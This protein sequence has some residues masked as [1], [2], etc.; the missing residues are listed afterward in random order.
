MSI[1]LKFGGTSLQN[2]QRMVAAAQRIQQNAQ[3][4]PVIVVASAMGGVTRLLRELAG[5]LPSAHDTETV[6]SILRQQHWNVLGDL[7]GL[8]SETH[9]ELRELFNQLE[10][11]VREPQRT[12]RPNAWTDRLLGFGERASVRLLTFTLNKLGQP[13][14]YYES[15]TFIKTDLYHGAARILEDES[16]ALVHEYLGQSHDHIPVVTGFI[17]ETL[18]HRPTTL[19]CSGSDYTASWIAAQL[20]SDALE[21]W[22]D[23][24]GIHTADP[25]RITGAR[26]IHSLNFEQ[27]HRLTQAGSSVIHPAV[28]EP[29]RSHQPELRIRN[30]FNPEHPG[31]TVGEQLD[32]HSDSQLGIYSVIRQQV[33]MIRWQSPHRSAPRLLLDRLPILHQQTSSRTSDEHY[34]HCLVLKTDQAWGLSDELQRLSNLEIESATAIRVITF[35]DPL[36]SDLLTKIRHLFT[37]HQ[38]ISVPHS[39][40]PIYIIGD[41][42]ADRLEQQLHDLLHL[43][44]IPIPI[45]LLGLGNVGQEF[46]DQLA[47]HC[48]ASSFRLI[49]VCDSQHLWLDQ[50]GIDLT[51]LSKATLANQSSYDNPEQLKQLLL[52]I[53][54]PDSCLIDCS[55][56]QEIAQWYPEFLKQGYHIITPSKHAGASETARYQQLQDEIAHQCAFFG[57]ETT[58]GAGLPLLLT[59][60]RLRRAGD[61]I[62]KL[63]IIASGSLN[64]I[65]SQLENGTL[66]SEAVNEAQQR[67]LTEPDPREDL[68]GQD[69]AR[70]ARILA[71]RVGW[72]IPDSSI[73]VHPL[74]TWSLPTLRDQKSRPNNSVSKDTESSNNLSRAD[75]RDRALS[76]KQKLQAQN[77]E[78][79]DRIQQTE[80]HDKVLRYVGTIDEH[81]IEVGLQALDQDHELAQTQGTQN[82]FIIHTDYYDEQPLIIKGPGAGVEVTASGVLGDLLRLREK[83]V[84]ARP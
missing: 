29:L 13:A 42:H 20:Q 32:S 60:D 43:G 63:E 44:E 84:G 12:G 78:W 30:S 2:T 16:R 55:G 28:L 56:N 62:R 64:F 3:Q 66:L 26:S 80:S 6:L 22:T 40:S 37:K 59:I 14:R 83:Q 53:A 71:R 38:L 24:D 8:Q 61:A 46:I 9:T 5:L 21:I 17:G 41:E 7:N 52:D 39:R 81:R 23:V 19:G 36:P 1:V 45:F 70:K 79:Q 35:N 82:T 69:V 33:S 77:K 57:D 27:L 48:Q 68:S 25:A 67:G 15:N 74:L 65:L 4:Q 18:D 73:Q 72:E 34:E 76:F 10:I 54:A 51:Q 47:D 31:T 75:A 58:V 11:H 50:Q 49:G